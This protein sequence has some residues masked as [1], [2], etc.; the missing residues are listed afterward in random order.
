MELTVMYSPE[1]R[2]VGPG[3]KRYQ[4]LKRTKKKRG[5]VNSIKLDQNN[6]EILITNNRQKE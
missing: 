5:N 2:G 3:V 4:K 6:L 1:K